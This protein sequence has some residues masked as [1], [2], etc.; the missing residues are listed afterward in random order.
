MITSGN[1]GNG[2]EVVEVV[3][4]VVTGVREDL[5]H[6]MMTRIKSLVHYIELII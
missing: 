3:L 1:I 5:N 2:V 4:M 6:G